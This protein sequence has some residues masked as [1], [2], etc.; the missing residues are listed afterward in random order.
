M[1]IRIASITRTMLSV[2]LKGIK[3]KI[4]C[5]NV[6]LYALLYLCREPEFENHSSITQCLKFFTYYNKGK[7]CSHLKY[8][9]LAVFSLIISS[10]NY[11]VSDF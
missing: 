4:E 9:H 6:Q 8:M 7:S 11:C 10:I 5:H 2:C 3:L 1:V